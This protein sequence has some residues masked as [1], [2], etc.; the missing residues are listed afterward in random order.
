MSVILLS[1]IILTFSGVANA[2]IDLPQKTTFNCNTWTENYPSIIKPNC[3]GLEAIMW[4]NTNLHNQIT[5]SANYSAGNGGNGWR[6]WLNDG[7]N[8][9]SDVYGF[10][11]N[12]PQKEIWCRFYIR[13]Q[14]GFAWQGGS[15]YYHKVVYLYSSSGA[16]GGFEWGHT[17]GSGRVNAWSNYDSTIPTSSGNVWESLF[18]NGKSDGSWH[19]WEFHAKM[20]TNSSNGV[21]ELWIDGVKQVSSSTMNWSGGNA[22]VRSQGWTKFGLSI[23]QHSPANTV[24]IG[25]PAYVDFDDIAINNTGYIGPLFSTIGSTPADNK[26]PAIPS[27][28]EVTIK[29]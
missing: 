7:N 26:A 5:S 16:N 18:P 11:F 17:G 25:S 19:C 24:G 15:P 22:T 4:S 6:V 29:P 28:V 27:S 20:D 1:L 14:I 23:N 8:N 10:V 9:N 12:T 21:G 13:Y 2:G 3:D